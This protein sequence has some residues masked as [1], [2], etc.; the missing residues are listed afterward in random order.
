VPAVSEEPRISIVTPCLNDAGDLEAMLESVRA[1]GYPNLEHIVVD[2]GSTDG[3]L[4]RLA[5]AAHV[6]LVS[7]PDRS[8]AAAINEGFRHATGDIW[9]FLCPADTLLAGALRRVAAE[10]DPARGR[11]VVMGRARLLDGPGGG[12]GIQHGSRSI[13]HRR[14][15]EV[16]KGHA[17]AQPAVFWTPAVWAACG[18]M[19]DG[20]WGDYDLFCRFA[21]RYRFHAIDQLL[22]TLRVDPPSRRE[23]WTGPSR[24][25]E[26]I[27][28]SRRH[29]GEPWRPT[30]WGL[31][32]SLA[33]FRVDRVGRARRRVREAEERWRRGQPLRGTW[34]VLAGAALAPEVA[35]YVRV[36]PTL[37]AVGGRVWRSARARGFRT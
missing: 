36:Y 28:I 17:V 8:P 16:W 11:H 24:L 4:E 18:P 25:E 1:Q 20:S 34:A 32:M 10:I 29:W 9:G 37:R 5:R 33:L 15:L 3:S 12:I 26:A 23:R 2:G 35:F 14:L 7:I 27:R 19:G 22:A 13:D 21:R 30:F 6:T 31:A